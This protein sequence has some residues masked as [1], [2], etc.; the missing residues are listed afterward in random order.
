MLTKTDEKRKAQKHAGKGDVHGLRLNRQIGRRDHKISCAYEGNDEWHT[1]ACQIDEQAEGQH[2]RDQ[3]LVK[4]IQVDR[5][6]DEDV[7]EPIERDVE[8][9][10]LRR[11]VR[12]VIAQGIAQI[13]GLVAE[14]QVEHMLEPEGEFPAAK[15]QEQDAGADPGHALGGHGLTAISDFTIPRNRSLMIFASGNSSRISRSSSNVS[16]RSAWSTS[17]CEGLVSQPQRE[18]WRI[19]RRVM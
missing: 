19:R 14:A 3:L 18:K 16:V 17:T 12:R 6:A 7:L 13:F 15:E 1:A 8:R 4:E 11:I 2:N 10:P 5:V 9:G